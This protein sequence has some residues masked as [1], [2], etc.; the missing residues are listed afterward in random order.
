MEAAW[1]RVDCTPYARQTRV[2]PTL[3]LVKDLL[4]ARDEDPACA[5]LPSERPVSRQADVLSG[6]GLGS[7]GLYA[8]C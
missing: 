6:S 3:A 4:I 5:L 7:R 1:A 2:A 8:L